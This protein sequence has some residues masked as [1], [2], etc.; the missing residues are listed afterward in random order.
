MERGCGKLVCLSIAKKCNCRHYFHLI[1]EVVRGAEMVVDRVSE[2]Q[3]ASVGISCLSLI[4]LQ[5]ILILR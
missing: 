1:L 4:E 3:I 5:N 2:S